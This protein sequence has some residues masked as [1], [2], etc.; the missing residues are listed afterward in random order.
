MP[1]NWRLRNVTRH[2][3]IISQTLSTCSMIS[4]LFVLGT[5]MTLDTNKQQISF[6]VT[7][8][9]RIRCSQLLDSSMSNT[10]MMQRF[11]DCNQA[12]ME[13][14]L[15]Y[16]NLRGHEMMVVVLST[17]VM[18]RSRLECLRGDGEVLVWWWWLQLA[19]CQRKGDEY[20]VE[21][22]GGEL[23]MA[24]FEVVKEKH[25]QATSVSRCNPFLGL[26]NNGSGLKK[27]KFM[28]LLLEIHLT[29]FNSISIH[30]F[31]GT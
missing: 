11:H 29:N 6:N 30:S 2:S 28:K 26:I 23:V 14:S 1:N 5:Y 12:S 13:S 20:G 18:G 8:K 31:C 3:W 22:V 9:I 21:G 17:A 15:Y 7:G 25:W 24:A 4:I 19:S 10:K 16:L 27:Y